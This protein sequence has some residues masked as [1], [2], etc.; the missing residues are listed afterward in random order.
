MIEIP[1]EL[2]ERRYTIAIGHGLARVL[3]DLLGSHHGPRRIALVSGRRIFAL[4]G[5]AVVRSLG[6]LGPVRP[7]LIPDGER[8]KNRRT[9]DSPARLV[10][11]GRSRPRRPGGR[12]RRRRRRRRG[13]LRGRH[14]HA[15][16]ST[17]WPSPPP[18]SP[19]STAR[20][21][22][23]SASTTRGAKNLIGAFHQPRAVVIDPIFL[24]TLPSREV[25][26][27]GL[28][29][30]EVRHPRRPRALREPPRGAPG[31]RGWD[32]RRH[33]ER[34][35]REPAGSRPRSW[36]RTSARAGL[37]RV[38]N[39]GHTLGHALE[40][41]TRYRRFTHGE[42][43]GWGLIGAAWIARRRGLLAERGLRR[44][45]PSA[46]DRLGPRPR[47]SDLD[48]ADLLDAVTRDKK[49]RDGRACPSSSRSAIGRVVV[50]RRR[51]P[52][53]DQA[54]PARCWPPARSCS[55]ER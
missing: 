32:A 30:P 6:A 12:P 4:H 5:A 34:H 7:V 50:K 1:V 52:R 13:R 14:L 43:V 24:D 9:L 20:S 19:W 17:G 28:R 33:R 25:Q 45:S 3:P 26:E 54:R 16:A 35:R 11:R 10:P 46:V 29:D 27:R 49:A 53:R 42:A 18:C 15:R 22:A 40:A 51:G 41:V 21:G 8:F 55:T 36:R 2:G 31:P 38:L 37:R 47:V 39:L 44:R 23:R 48:P